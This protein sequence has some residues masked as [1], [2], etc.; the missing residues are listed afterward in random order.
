MELFHFACARIATTCAFIFHLIGKQMEEHFC[1][2][3]ADLCRKMTD[4]WSVAELSSVSMDSR[5]DGGLLQS[6]DDGDDTTD[7][8]KAFRNRLLGRCGAG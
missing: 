1:F 3:Y 6:R 2:M 4:K 8:G 5:E 7:L